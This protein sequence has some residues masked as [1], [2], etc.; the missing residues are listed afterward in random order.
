MSEIVFQNMPFT[1]LRGAFGLL[2]VD[3]LEEVV[4]ACSSSLTR[5]APLAPLDPGI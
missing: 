3:S 1:R 2:R 5:S 4:L